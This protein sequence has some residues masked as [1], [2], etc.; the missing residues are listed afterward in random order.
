MRIEQAEQPD[1]AEQPGPAGRVPL[2]EVAREWGRIGVTGFGGPP[3]HIALLRALCVRRRGWIP[4]T[5]F[6][7]AIATVNLLPGPASTQLAI[8][9]G[10]RLRG[11]AGA[12][13]AGFCF[14]VPG[15]VLILALAAVLLASHPPTWVLG[16]AAGAGAAVPAVAV[17][18]AWGLAPAS[19]KRIRQGAPR[20]PNTP[21]VRWVGYALAGGAAA[22]TIGPYLVLVLVACGVIEVGCRSRDAAAGRTPAKTDT[23]PKSDG[24]GSARRGWAV[25]FGVTKVG[26]VATAGGLSA[27]VWTAFKVGALSYGGGFVI[28]PLMQHDAVTTYHWLSAARFLDAVALGQITPGP[29]VQTVAVV[30]YAAAGVGGGL[31]AASVA[32]AP[33]FLFVLLGARHFDALRGNRRVQAFLTGAGPAVIGAIAGAAIPLTMALGHGWQYPLTVAAAAWLLL[34]RRGVVSTLLLSAACGLAVALAGLPVR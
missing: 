13:V 22:A 33:S 12:L 29:V 9:C 11:R 20:H 6:E 7:D 10:W 3:A 23:P 8:W 1:R 27:L 19:W 15:L 16:L 4:A 24:S 5:E 2:V 21:R 28:I 17:H 18:A 25:P 14:I 31:L 34:A 30:G 32:F 26:A